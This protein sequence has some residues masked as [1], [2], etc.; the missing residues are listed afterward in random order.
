[1]EKR[2][3]LRQPLASDESAVLSFR[4]TFT[5]HNAEGEIPGSGGLA[6]AESYE[7]WLR[8]TE[9]FA[10]KATVPDGMVQASTFLAQL[11]T[12]ARLVG[13]IQI[14]HTLNDYLMRF[15][16]HI[17]YSVAPGERGK[18]YATE[19]L[20]LALET[21]QQIGLQKVLIT[22]DKTNTASAAVI[23]A[24]GGVL[25]NEIKD[26]TVTKQRYWIMLG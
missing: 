17:G 22:C 4:T 24:N 16:G 10:N 8:R 5:G 12:D 3:I 26:A 6:L 23:V 21:C 20:R 1:M 25:E 7:T 11:Q 15:G 2:F 18:G 13:I 14:R 19:M 9:L